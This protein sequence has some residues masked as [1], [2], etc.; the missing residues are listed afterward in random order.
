TDWLLEDDSPTARIKLKDDKPI[1]IRVV[2]NDKAIELMALA[3]DVGN[4]IVYVDE[5]S[6]VIPP[7]SKPPRAFFDI[8]Q[9]GRSR[10]VTLWSSTQRP[11]LIPL[12]SI[13]EAT[14]FFIFRLN[15][16][17]DRKTITDNASIEPLSPARYK[18]NRFGFYYIND[19][20]DRVRFFTRLVI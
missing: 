3:Y 13:S 4:V 9:R 15:L 8:I 10:N 16:D 18:Q 5:L 14:H 7:R 17:R 12:E 2:S 20:T 6:S 11:T 19:E 1:R